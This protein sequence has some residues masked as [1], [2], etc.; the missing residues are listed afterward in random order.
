MA[1]REFPVYSDDDTLPA[2]TDGQILLADTA[3][4]DLFP[5][6]PNQAKALGEFFRKNLAKDK[7]TR[8]DSAK[9]LLADLRAVQKLEERT[10]T[11]PQKPSTSSVPSEPTVIPT[12][13]NQAPIT[14]LAHLVDEL[15]A[16]AGKKDSSQRKFVSRVLGVVDSAPADPFA[17]NAQYAKSLNVTPGRIPQITQEI[18]QLWASTNEL[19]TVYEQV[20]ETLKDEIKGNGGIATPAELAPAV[21]KLFPDDVADHQTRTL[22]GVIRLVQLSLEKEQDPGQQRQFVSL[23]RGITQTL[24]ALANPPGFGTLHHDLA[25]SVKHALAQAPSGIIPASQLTNL[26]T[27][28]TA[29]SLHIQPS[30]IPFKLSML[31]ELATTALNKVALT[32]TGDVY[33]TDM[34]AAQLVA[35]V[36]PRT[37]ERISRKDLKDLI[38]TRF[39][40]AELTELPKHPELD[41]LVQTQSPL[42]VYDGQRSE[43][44]LPKQDTVTYVETRVPTSATLA[45]IQAEGYSDL[46]A[47]LKA[48][49]PERQF[50]FVATNLHSTS[51]IVEELVKEFDVPHVDVTRAVFNK[52]DQVASS[53]QELI[54]VLAAD[55]PQHAQQMHAILRQWSQEVLDEALDT[56]APAVILTDISILVSYGNQDLLE[57]Y[58]DITANHNRSAIWVVIPEEAH[59]SAHGLEIEG[60]SIS[61]SSTN[62]L[63]KA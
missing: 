48:T 53:E 16:H 49:I 2:L 28:A 37:A 36:F 50:R 33:A 23:R 63:V 60:H 26:L 29:S 18:P 52:L 7:A 58:M 40:Q 15:R 1:T 51:A 62:Q 45:Q 35:A 8:A 31:P 27:K 38:N 46:I 39:P 43:Y 42:M 9:Q 11:S 56:T 19:A 44:I 20:R 54:N 4:Q 41:T 10:T 55:T 25:H 32:P 59:S 12:P 57:R 47:M 6:R 30:A 21:S 22:L 5:G 3:F 24:I 14:G 34:T 17:P 61:L 13:D